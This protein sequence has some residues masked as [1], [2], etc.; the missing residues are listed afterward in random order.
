MIGVMNG[1]IDPFVRTDTLYPKYPNDPFSAMYDSEPLVR[2]EFNA[3]NER[4]HMELREVRGQGTSVQNITSELNAM[5]DSSLLRENAE[6]RR[7]EE[8]RRA[9][10]THTPNRYIVKY[11][12]WSS[13]DISSM[14]RSRN[15]LKSETIQDKADRSGR[16][17]RNSGRSGKNT[18]SR[19]EVITLA[20]RVNPQTLA[21]ELRRAGAD[22]EIEYI[23]P[24]IIMSLEGA[25]EHVIGQ[26]VDP[27]NSFEDDFIEE[28]E[29]EDDSEDDLTEEDDSYLSIIRY[30]SA[31]VAVIDTGIDT[32]HPALN[33]YVVEGWNFPA[34]SS[35]TY[36]PNNPL[37]SAH[38]THI[39]GAI[40]ETARKWGAN[41]EI[42]P[43]QVFDNGVAYTS[44]ILAAIQY[45]VD[46]GASVINCSFG[47]TSDNPA[48]ADAIANAGDTLFVASAGNSRRNL[49]MQSSYP[50]AYR[51]NNVIS[52]GSVNADGGFSYFSD[53]STN[54]VDITAI[55]RDVTSAIPGGG[56]GPMSGT[57]MATAHIS[58][59]AAV[60]A[61]QEMQSASIR[62]RLLNSADR[63]DNLQNKVSDGRR[64]NTINAVHGYSGQRLSLNPADDFDVHGYSPTAEEQW[65]LFFSGRV[66]QVEAGGYHSLA[67]KSDG[68]VWAWGANWNGQL[69]DGTT[70]NKSAP[71]QVI[72]LTGITAIS[73]G[74]GHSL[75]LKSDGTVWA[76][77]NN[78]LG[79]LGD[80]TRI[81]K[82]TPVQVL[83]D[84][85]A[86]S[87]GSGH[88]L[89]FNSNWGHT[90][91]A[92]GSNSYGQVGDSN[93]NI[94]I[95]TPM[96]V[97][98]YSIHGSF[99]EA[100]AIT[101]GT[102]HSMVINTEGEVWGWGFNIFGQLGQNTGN[103]GIVHRP[104]QANGL[105]DATVITA[106]MQ[107]MAIRFNGTLWVWGANFEGEHGDGTWGAKSR[108]TLVHRINGVI[109]IATGESY[110]LA[111][112][113]DGTVWSSGY[114][115][116]GQL[117]DETTENRATF[118][119]IMGLTEI[120]D[121]SAGARHSL[122]LA[123]D[124]TVW[125]WG[126]NEFGQLGD[127]VIIKRIIPP[128]PQIAT[129]LE[130]NVNPN[131]LQ[132]PVS[133][134]MA[135]AFLIAT[136]Y[137]EN[138]DEVTCNAAAY[139][140][141]TLYPGVLVNATTGMVTV[142][143]DAQPGTVVLKVTCDGFTATTELVLT[144][145]PIIATILELSINPNKLQIPTDGA[146]VDALLIATLY[147][148][149][150]DEMIGYEITY[151]LESLNDGVFVDSI[152]GIMTI[153][154][155]A[156]PGVVTLK[157]TYNDLITT[158][159]LILTDDEFVFDP[160]LTV[161]AG[162]NIL[163]TLSGQN[164]Q[165][166]SNVY[167]FTYDATV[168]S[169]K[170]FAAQIGMGSVQSGE[171]AQ[172][173]LEIISLTNGTITFRV[174]KAIPSGKSWSGVITVLRFQAL[175]SGITTLS[176]E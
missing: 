77:G 63:L 18:N 130:L 142:A 86:I 39:A 133:G 72:G 67:M 168:L 29:D 148:Q 116:D 88:S 90:V 73:A 51:F 107:S 53:Y 44:D 156:E 127:G 42:L 22:R 126:S 60:L 13:T 78:N 166:F 24:D 129:T 155:N 171:I 35:V 152:S 50:A 164:I 172:T 103:L 28:I 159:K 113:F 124:G 91:L 9:Y 95:T 89:A 100:A 93:F 161:T 48:L 98:G 38:G 20:E 160:I 123:S 25:F 157:A 111:L 149:N 140:L 114:N 14:L 108:P 119:Q 99:R 52:V 2:Q 75:A 8:E 45:A 96:Q 84:M 21:D 5:N 10:E 11:R 41:V 139:S 31:L 145:V 17:H 3:V 173:D 56:Y 169:L 76:W 26:A 4:Y 136:L 7:A 162:Q 109:G 59:V 118:E 132:I 144:T 70:I 30:G 112:K 115:E 106:N 176:V 74:G 135:E 6:L 85:T 101:A 27:D 46:S 32:S 80:G 120:I 137:N 43:L 163:V 102:Y 83:T 175:Q 125:A 150:G 165:N 87:A 128:A 69:G 1:I 167:T 131:K 16:N 65:E 141:S 49:D 151:G 15:V 154:S 54:L 55:G 12:D 143:S 40:A 117:G 134:A 61:A 62:A 68:T 71:V 23:Q 121:I 92:W 66:I 19:V 170:D 58:G 158:T 64:L 94:S 97:D 57:S 81:N 36:D 47:S 146:M 122:A 79:Q 104:I 174:N 33:G 138:G 34:S 105:T 147:D 153:I 82:T 37:A 110:S